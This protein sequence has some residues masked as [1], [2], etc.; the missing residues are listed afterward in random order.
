MNE[1]G[2]ILAD[3]PWWYNNRKTGGER[4][5]KTKFGGGARKHYP[6]MKDEEVLAMDTF[7]KGLAAPDCALFLWA[8]GPRLDFA[9][10]VLKKWGFR[11]A[12][13]AF[14][15]CKRT[16]DDTRYKYGPG[17]YTASNA[18]YVLLGVKGRVCPAKRM[19]PSIVA[20]PREGHSAKPGA[21]LQRISLMYP[22]ARKIE[23]FARVKTVGW[24]AW[25]NEV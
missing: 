17:Y 23:L 15:W 21:V 8:T 25:G 14:V 20:T 3:P 4:C 19:L 9:F 12:T 5:D 22:K 2:V 7:V 1:Y 10:E 24:D 6:L 18:E 16:A 11:Y 13:T